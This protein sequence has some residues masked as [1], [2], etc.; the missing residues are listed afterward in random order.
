MF[1]KLK[2]L[3]Q[4]MLPAM[5]AGLPILLVAIFVLLNVAIWWAGPWLTINDSQPLASITA[6]AITSVIFSLA[7]LAL[8]GFLQWRKL[9]GYH[10]DQA[11]E[12]Q[13]E[14]DPIKRFEERQ[15][16]ELNQVMTS[17]QKSLNKRNY[18]YALPWYLVLG[19]ENAGKTSLINRSGQNFVFSSV[20]RAS[21][22]KSENPFS[23]DWW[24]GDDSVLI[25]P[26]GELL[27]QRATSNDGE[28]ELERRL[29]LHFIKWLEKTR[30]RRPLNGVVIA[31][32]V[33]NLA[34]S[35]TSERRAYANLL[36]TRLRELME[37]L[38]TRLP[39]YVSLT[40]LDLLHG[41]EPFFR[42]CSKAERE[43]V[44]GFTFTLDSVDDLDSW[45]NE[46]DKDFGA[47]VERINGMLPSILM[48]TYDGEDRTAIYSFSRQMAGMHDVLKQFLHDAFGSDQF[49]TSALVRGVYFTSVYQ[50][51]VPTNAFI[52]S[53]SRR[54]GISHAVNSAQNAN[55]STTYFTQRLFSKVIYPEAGLASD[56]FRVA[57]TK[58]RVMMLSV[59]ACSI[60][61]VLL[62]GSWHQY[63]LKNVEQADAVLT[64]VNEY[65]HNY[66]SDVV[67]DNGVDILAPLDTIRQATL[68]FGFFRDKPQHFSDLGLYQ[69]HVIGPEVERTY[70]SLLENRYLPALLKT[71]AAEIAG[72]QDDEQMLT[73]LRVFR[74]MTDDD[75]RYKN[76]VQNYFAAEW[77]EQYP[78]DRQ[79]QE[80]LM[81]HLDYAMEH[82]DLEG[83]RN[84][85]QEDAE[86]ILS[87][88]DDLIANTQRQLSRMPIEQ[89]VY[90]NLKQAST[91]VLGAP[92]DL[93][94]AIG[95][96]FDVVFTQRTEE[97]SD[98][99]IPRVLTKKG[100]NSY[101]IPESDSV[102]ELALV[103]SWV[104]GQT[105]SIDF[106]DEDKR[107]LREKIRSQ[108]IADYSD[109]WRRAMND[110]D[111]KYFPD[112]HN[113]VLVLESITGNNQPLH[114][115]LEEITD[116]T[117]LFPQLPENDAAR[118]ELT[119]SPR[120]RV[121]ALVDN[122]FSE[123]NGLAT[124]EPGKPIYLDEVVDAVSQLTAY[125]KS[126]NDSPDVGK[127]ALEA[128]KARLT[129]NSSDPIYVLER[130]S[131]GMP[132]P[133]DTMLKKLADESWYV[134]RQEAI[135]YLEVR[136][137]TDVYNE[138]RTKLASRYPFNPA[139][140][141]DVALEDFE[142]FFAPNGIL[143]DFYE[144]NLKMFLEDAGNFDTAEGEKTLIRNDVLNQLE[145]ARDIQQAF[146]N[147]KGV[148]D[149][150][151]TLEPVELSANKRRSVINIDGQY[152][153]YSHGPRKN[154]GLIWPNTLRE[155]AVSKITL[156]PVAANTSPRSISIS[157]PWAFF[158]LLEQAEVVGST[159]TS[160]DYRFN[161]DSGNVMYRLH[162]E[163][164]SNPFTA[165]IFRGF[166][167]SR[168]L[169]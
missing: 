165:S 122:Q 54:Y 25:D 117:D 153:E 98:L 137:A 41:F 22:K 120:Y 80:R 126:I 156:V 133:Y 32:D 108:Y 118:D 19:P 53:A 136:W 9:K 2:S 11:R 123:L 4:K 46:F 44:L 141:K 93:A 105:E 169:Y 71:A 20:M 164:D 62:I 67:I 10:A 60:A 65:E 148:L 31:L 51:G 166:K 158:R 13:L 157:G 168:T 119:K 167:L 162:S 144:N 92:V 64:K 115:L 152:V 37:T 8:W 101:F 94:T 143:T 83:D 61:S 68:E 74:M 140:T 81:Q 35:T 114:R 84:A 66:S 48:Q 42:H 134:I 26:D 90:R 27:T 95:P 131:T 163:A 43:E 24:I 82:T 85:G 21:G 16:S 39:V 47:F 63:Y 1:S 50:Q 58:R 127:A 99:E 57:K 160:V 72:A 5:K 45:L 150:E 130:I 110:I 15:E 29:W 55:N 28:G 34:T 49:S 97:S 142:A 86:A 138:F 132:Q 79:T 100:F 111:I 52:D 30:S 121:A 18:L 113:A 77:Q 76:M 154:V 96:V 88:Y 56:N 124:T 125:M 33:A 7:W 69:G 70:L 129:L 149:V 135:R 91:S 139:S 36:R 107:V 109:S 14:D 40:K 12:R 145:S 75:G 104:L 102:S 73:S 38:S 159:A 128:T 116:N 151:F 6:R 147:R 112:I 87:P 78:G 161:I 146:F 89:R 17:L 103:D 106:S 3:L 59:V 23:F 155:A